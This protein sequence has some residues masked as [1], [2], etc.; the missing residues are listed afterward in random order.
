MIVVEVNKFDSL[1]KA[2]KNYKYRVHKSKIHDELR[3]RKEYKKDSV[4]RRELLKKARY[5]QSKKN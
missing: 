4:K 2:L 3:E 5:A 1:D